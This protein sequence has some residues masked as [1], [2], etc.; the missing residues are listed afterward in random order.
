MATESRYP[1]VPERNKRICARYD[2]GRASGLSLDDLGNEFGISRETV[3]RVLVKRDRASRRAERLK[4]LR[5][6]FSKGV[7]RQ[8]SGR[9]Q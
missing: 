4:P 9:G 7:G 6:A 8:V 1:H 2:E 5:D 3:R